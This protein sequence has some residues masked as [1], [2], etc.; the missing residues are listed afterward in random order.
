MKKVISLFL[1]SLILAS[2]Y[3]Q[4]LNTESQS[5]HL[6]SLEIIGARSAH[7]EQIINLSGLAEGMQITVPGFQISDAIKRLYASDL[8][9]DVQI[10]KDR[11]D[12]ND[13]Y[14]KLVLIERARVSGFKITGLKKRQMEDLQ[15]KMGLVNGAL[16]SPAKM[17][18]AKRI[19]RNYLIEKGY[20]RS[21]ILVT[22]KADP[23]LK[24]GIVLSFEVKKGPKTKIEAIH[25]SGNE[26]FSQSELRKPLKSLP[27]KTALR[28][29]KKSKFTE[30]ALDIARNE[31]L[32]FYR[33]KGFR[34][35]EIVS[36]SVAINKSGHISLYLELEEGRRFYHRNIRFIGNYTYS[37]SILNLALGINNGDIYSDAL[38]QER[39]YGGLKHPG[40]SSLYLDN[41][42]L[43]FRIDPI[44]SGIRGDSIDLDL[45]IQ[46]GAPTTIGKITLTGNTKTSDEV[47]MRSLRTQ[48]GHIFRR[49]DLI[50]SQRELIA[51]NYFD[52]ETM[53]I[54]PTPNAE[55]GTVDLE[56]KLAEKPSDRIQLSGGWS[57][58]STDSD[59]NVTGGGLVGTLQLTLNNFSTKRLFNP[60][61]WN[62][63]PGGDGQQLNLAFQSTGRSNNFSINFLEP[64][65][66][67]KKPNSFGVGLNYYNFESEISGDDGNT[68]LF[69]TRSFA[70]SVDYGT[71]L[72][73]PDDYTQSRT[74]LSYRNYDILNPGLFYPEFE[75][76]PSAFV[77]SITLNQTFTRNSLDHPMFP[78][79]GSFNE[80]SAEFTPPYSLF[81][82]E[83]DYEN[84]G[85]A[86]KFKFLEYYK[87][88]IKSQWF[89]NP[90][91]KLV[92]QG[93]WDAGYLGAY[94]AALGVSPF[95]R[96]VL[97]G[98][99]ILNANNGGIRGIDPIPLRGYKAQVFDNDGSYFTLFN[100]LSFEVRHPIELSPQF[101]I[102]VLGFAEMGSASEGFSNFSLSDFKRS[103]GFGLRMQVPM[104]GLLGLDWGYG[105]DTDPSGIKSGG[106]VHFI[107]GR[108][109]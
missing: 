73:F 79:S 70:A 57:P 28:F 61:A 107:F 71:F 13:I 30:Q 34:D 99:G 39:I 106:Q 72:N 22:Q 86:E 32:A 43:F 10:Q 25:L 93:R 87:I 82:E 75:G 53:D 69:R 6:K 108:E 105:F 7:P 8:F 27:K 85:A 5:F 18:K 76:E 40:L 29:W 83:K 55:T 44:E 24:S 51:M 80:I 42:H 12:G 97:G 20:Y 90:I 16:F 33:N 104:I 19:I 100:R 52:P 41:G 91:G 35:I 9:E 92:L 50:R 64:W 56:Y 94:N 48:P 67:G 78:S 21:E 11:I 3:A 37:D 15:D 88:R 4:S 26:N 1:L 102:W 59:G 49:N 95:E 2:T 47:I 89:L 38:L 109:F 96:F 101:P 65:L 103:A 46:E 74:S 54:I 98:A 45:R 60:K 58:R 62:P 63:I 17:V 31:I 36:D 77:N 66:G 84:M 81:G 23:I 68:D 14:L